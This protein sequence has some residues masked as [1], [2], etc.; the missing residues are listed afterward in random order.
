MRMK[1]AGVSTVVC[2]ACSPRRR[3]PLA[4]TRRRSTTR[5]HS[6]HSAGRRRVARSERGRL[7]LAKTKTCHVRAQHARDVSPTRVQAT[8]DSV[9]CVLLLHLLPSVLVRDIV[10][11]ARR[12]RR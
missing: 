11:P 9:R 5:H 1:S 6:G 2:L 7:S 3:S 10:G 8:E 12:V 4:G